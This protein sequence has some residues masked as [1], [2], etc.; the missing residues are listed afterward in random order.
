MGQNCKTWVPSIY[1]KI[2]IFEGFFKQ[3]FSH[4]RLP[5]VKISARLNNVWGVR[6]QKI[7]KKGDFMDAES[8]QKTFNFTTTNTILVKRTTDIYVNKVFHLAKSRSVT[9]KV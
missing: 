7:L 4:W 2:K 3:Y 1:I 6:A 8:M 5:L 9:H